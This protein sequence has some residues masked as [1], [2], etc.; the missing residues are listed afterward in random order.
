M[1]RRYTITNNCT[2]FH[3][4]L[5]MCHR[6]HHRGLHCTRQKAIALKLDHF[7]PTCTTDITKYTGPNAQRILVTKVAQE[8]EQST[9]AYWLAKSIEMPELLELL[10]GKYQGYNPSKGASRDGMSCVSNAWNCWFNYLSANL[11]PLPSLHLCSY[12]FIVLS[13]KLSLISRR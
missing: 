10:S 13:S 1:C 2:H 6:G 7:C 5:Q 8:M 4:H 12:C 3:E 11:K 9:Q